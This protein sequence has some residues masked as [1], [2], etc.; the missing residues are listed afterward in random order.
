M[1]ICSVRTRPKRSERAPANQPPKAEV[2]SV[3]VPISPASALVIAKATMI[4]GIAKLKICT[5]MASSLQPPKHAQNVRFS[6]GASSR[7]HPVGLSYV[8]AIAL[9]PRSEEHTS[10]LQ[11]LRHIV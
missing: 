4:A 3:A 7:Y 8:L 11:S 1:V 2:S 9:P 5:S 10:E 6:P